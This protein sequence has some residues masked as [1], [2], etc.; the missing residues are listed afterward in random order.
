MHHVADPSLGN[1]LAPAQ[2]A[3]HIVTSAQTDHGWSKDNA[4]P[5]AGRAGSSSSLVAEDRVHANPTAKQFAFGPLAAD[6][7]AQRGINTRGGIAPLAPAPRKYRG[8]GLHVL[9]KHR[10]PPRKRRDQVMQRGRRV[11]TS[12]WFCLSA[13]TR[14][15]ERV[16]KVASTVVTALAAVRMS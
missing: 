7:M 13:L 5:L 9:K 1:E 6:H 4:K 10:Q 8:D 11:I 12:K 2:H 16:D 3:T 14:A 15:R